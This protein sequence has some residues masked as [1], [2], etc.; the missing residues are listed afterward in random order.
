[1]LGGC[2]TLSGIDS[3]YPKGWPLVE[4]ADTNCPNLS[5]D[6]QN[7]GSYSYSP[8]GGSHYLAY[9]FGM[10]VNTVRELDAIDTIRIHPVED[11]AVLVEARSSGVVV[12]SRRLSFKTKELSCSSGAMV[13][14]PATAKT[15]D[16]FGT[17]VKKSTVWFK[18][19]V[20]G[21]IIGEEN[22]STAAAALYVVPI[23]GSQTFWYRWKLQK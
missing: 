18:K 11:D 6:Y 19:G 17:A 2:S 23:V 21:S 3:N 15:L 8:L 14:A 5:G 10:H 16:G 13:F 9:R 7:R 20:D 1:M 4:S 22:S 12:M